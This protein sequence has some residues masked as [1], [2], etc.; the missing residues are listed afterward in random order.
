MNVLFK[1][2]N[3]GFLFF[4][5]FTRSYKTGNAKEENFKRADRLDFPIENGSMNKE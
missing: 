1:I 5:T 2:K 4:F 3:L